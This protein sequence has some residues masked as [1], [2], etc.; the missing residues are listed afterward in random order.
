MKAFWK[1]LMLAAGALLLVLAL[2][3]TSLAHGRFLKAF[4]FRS[5][6]EEQAAYQRACRFVAIC[7]KPVHIAGPYYNRPAVNGTGHWEVHLSQ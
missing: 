3:S 4:A 7:R 5:R 6:A 1:G 2:E